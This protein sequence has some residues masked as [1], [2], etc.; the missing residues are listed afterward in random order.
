MPVA[1]RKPIP[2]PP[3]VRRIAPS[4]LR[5]ARTLLDWFRAERNDRHFDGVGALALLLASAPEIGRAH[6]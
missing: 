5:Q 6:V 2:I 1:T 4:R 3:C